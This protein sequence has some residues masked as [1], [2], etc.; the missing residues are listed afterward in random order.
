MGVTR[1]R[2]KGTSSIGAFMLATD[3]YAIV[4]PDTPGKVIRAIKEN[5]EVK[6]V[7]SLIGES[8]LVGVLSAGNPKGLLVPY[9]ALDEELEALRKSLG[10]NVSRVP[11]KLTAIGNVVLTNEKACLASPEL[12]DDAIAVIEETL[13]VTVQRGTIANLP[14][15]GSSGVATGKGVIVHP[16]STSKELRVLEKLFGISVDVGTVNG[17]MPYVRVGLVANSVGAL[18]GEDTTGPE[19]QNLINILNIG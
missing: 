11:G 10:I 6:P 18:V 17:G 3:S 1:I 12:G 4:P 2:F 7:K 5:L 14:I 13:D 15:V 8:R 9:Y 16:N 19:I